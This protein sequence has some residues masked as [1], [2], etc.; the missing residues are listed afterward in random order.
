MV[1]VVN[2]GVE[3]LRCKYGTLIYTNYVSTG[4]GAGMGEPIEKGASC[5]LPHTTPV[6]WLWV[7]S[8]SVRG[9]GLG[10]ALCW[11]PGAIMDKPQPS[12]SL[13]RGWTQSSDG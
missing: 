6:T 3:D 10:R 12:A 4:A 2:D 8:P 11:G 9:P 13:P 5:T 7:G 1:D